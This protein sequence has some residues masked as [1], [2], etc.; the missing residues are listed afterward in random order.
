MVK[1]FDMNHHKALHIVLI[2]VVTRNDCTR[3]AIERIKC[4][5]A[6]QWSSDFRKVKH[7]MRK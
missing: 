2:Q 5:D 7:D 6:L 4:L 3:L 1:T